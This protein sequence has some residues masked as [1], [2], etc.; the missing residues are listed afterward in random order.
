VENKEAGNKL[1]QPSLFTELAL[2]EGGEG[3]VSFGM[4]S[5]SKQKLWEHLKPNSFFKCFTFTS[6]YFPNSACKP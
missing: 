6:R 1:A 2:I 5:N 4:K 3:D